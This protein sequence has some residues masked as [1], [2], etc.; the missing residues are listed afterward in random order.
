MVKIKTFIGDL[1]SIQVV[2]CPNNLMTYITIEITIVSLRTFTCLVTHFSLII[3][4]LVGVKFRINVAPGVAVA[5][6]ISLF[7][8]GASQLC[9]DYL[10]ELLG[11]RHGILNSIVVNLF[12]V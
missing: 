5:G 2:C 9:V 11:C 12:I 1:S 10:V 3:G 7:I 8:H 4:Y 6:S